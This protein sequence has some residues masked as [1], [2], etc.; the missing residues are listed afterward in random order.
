[1]GIHNKNIRGKKVLKEKTH[2]K[3]GAELSALHAQKDC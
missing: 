2:T 1:M 3:Q